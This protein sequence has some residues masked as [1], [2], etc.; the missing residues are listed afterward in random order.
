MVTVKLTWHLSDLVESD[1][2]IRSVK[3]ISLNPGSW[4]EFVRQLREL[5]PRLADRVFT[6]PEVIAPGYAIVLNGEV[7]N[8]DYNSLQIRSGDELYVLI[9]IAGG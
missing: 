6:E 4:R 7:F 5:Y 3:S 2:T 1:H 8:R 9:T